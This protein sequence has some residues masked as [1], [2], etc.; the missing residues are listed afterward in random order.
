MRLRAVLVSFAMGLSVLAF[1][2]PA[3]AS[4][5]GLDF[6][7]TGCDEYSDAVPRLYTA[8]F[9]RAPE[10][11]GFSFWLEQYTSGE[12]GLSRMAHFF[13]S[14]DEFAS[15]YGAL[16][17]EG[18]VNQ[19]YRNV[20]GRQG[21]AAGVDFWVGQIRD[22]GMTRGTLLLRF[23]ESPENVERSGT[24]PPALG[25]FNVGRDGA[26]ECETGSASAFGL[27]RSIEYG[28]LG[29]EVTTAK[30]LSDH[31]KEGQAADG[32]SYLELTVVVANPLQDGT[33]SIPAGMM[34]LEYGDNEFARGFFVESG[35]L[36][37]D[38]RDDATRKI[39]FEIDA[40][41]SLG[42]PVLVIAESG[43]EP[44]RLPLAVSVLPVSERRI[45]T[46]D[47][48]SF[49]HDEFD[50]AGSLA[51]VAWI[52]HNVEVVNRDSV[53]SLRCGGGST[54]GRAKEGQSYVHLPATV[55]GRA[56]SVTGIP[57]N[58]NAVN[59][60]V[61]AVAQVDGLNAQVCD[62]FGDILGEETSEFMVV[63]P[64]DSNDLVFRIGCPC[65]GLLTS[66]AW[67]DITTGELLN[68]SVSL[69]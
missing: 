8:A 54:L 39:Y 21:E 55:S 13:A 6:T 57:L 27:P 56:D 47:E 30:L 35:R 32:A 19:L 69:G 14:S 66:D 26:W 41:E 1:S 65:G 63:V 60:S 12:W 23:S 58:F 4:V 34:A 44:A 50:F 64:N 49:T 3:S 22:E 51:G 7:R 67:E 11:D 2:A 16:D 28:V 25:N 36:S 62:G 46:V 10:E 45:L 29:F 59:W 5:P 9:G 61:G 15:K 18:F 42:S 43:Y 24:T 37:I 68:V 53:V 38:P 33:F 40:G 20:L 31:P 48:A 52:D 17:E